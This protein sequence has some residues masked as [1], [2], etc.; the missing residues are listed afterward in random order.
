MSGTRKR[1]R[2]GTDSGNKRV[3][4][5]NH[6][7]ELN[8][9]DFDDGYQY[10][11]D[12]NLDNWLRQEV[13]SEDGAQTSIS[14][15]WTT[16]YETNNF[17]P[18][19]QLQNI[20]VP[21]LVGGTVQRKKQGLNKTIKGGAVAHSRIMPY[22]KEH[23][24]T[25]TVLSLKD[26]NKNEV[27]KVYG[28]S[29]P[30]MDNVEE[31]YSYFCKFVG[32]KT[33][34]SFQACDKTK[35]I[36]HLKSCNNMN[37][38]QHKGSKTEKQVW[39]NLSKKKSGRSKYKICPNTLFINDEWKD[40]TGPS[41]DVM[42]KL[43]SYPIWK[44]PT[45][46]HCLAGFGRTGTALFYYWFRTA[47]LYKTFL[48]NNPNKLNI[49]DV[50]TGYEGLTQPFLG[51]KILIGKTKSGIMFYNLM[52]QFYRCIELGYI[53]AKLK[54]GNTYD[55]YDMFKEL[56][57]IKTLTS[58]N[59]FLSRFNNILL[60][61]AIFLNTQTDTALFPGMPQQP[62]TEIYLYPLH[63]NYPPGKSEFDKDTIFVYPEYTDINNYIANNNF[64]L[65]PNNIPYTGK[66][67]QSSSSLTNTVLGSSLSQP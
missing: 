18:Q 42:N 21:A 8:K 43:I 5:T 64:G 67:L 45:M 40:M 58:A 47:I 46:I 24:N 29:L 4:I 1:N 25:L 16:Y 65:K 37:W 35:D 49:V 56:F 33:I 52:L 44:T 61:T 60:Y 17:K 59:L 15:L 22:F 48:I 27:C 7:D 20:P 2:S 57:K 62:I 38:T 28:S 13:E 31:L 54:D 14:E 11:I 53:D 9:R 51:Y 10:I 66:V 34:I 6:I 41:F 30:Y 12:N 19:V 23:F 63:M 50:L 39:E 3:N 55:V 26:N 32:I 36:V